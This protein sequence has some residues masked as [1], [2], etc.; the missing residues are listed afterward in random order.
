MKEKLTIVIPEHNRPKRLKRLLYFYLSNGYNNII[1]SDSSTNQFEYL[2]D[3]KDSIV[4]Y[5]FPKTHLVDKIVSI[6]NEVKTPYVVLCAE[7]DY[8]MPNALESIVHFLENNKEYKSAQGYWMQF[9]PKD[10]NHLRLL[11][12]QVT[13]ENSLNENDSKYRTIQLFEHYYQFYY[14]VM[15]KELFFS[16]YESIIENGKTKLDN[17]CLVEMW[18]AA[19]CSNH[20]KHAILPVFYAMREYI[21]GSA[22]HYVPTYAALKKENKEIEQVEFFESCMTSLVGEDGF[23]ELLEAY[24]RFGTWWLKSITPNFIQRVTNKID[25]SF[26]NNKIEQWQALRRMKNTVSSIDIMKRDLSNALDNLNK[27]HKFVYGK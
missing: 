27:Y 7:D 23:T 11:Y 9:W 8:M 18:Q 21:S 25:R 12:P 17:L 2:N 10:N 26:F 4:Y 13:K 3:F 16:S 22:G 5:H 19:F 15:T 14:V 1:V 20:G 24:H 6:K